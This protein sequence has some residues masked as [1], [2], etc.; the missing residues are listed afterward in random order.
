MHIQLFSFPFFLSFP[1][2]PIYFTFAQPHRGGCISGLYKASIQ[3]RRDAANRRLSKEFF[4]CMGKNCT[5][6]WLKATKEI[7][8]QAVDF[9]PVHRRS[10]NSPWCIFTGR[11]T[12]V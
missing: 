3:D 8:S 10:P 9:I 7:Y 5:P 11:E 1:P 12:N 4:C 6:G 2:K